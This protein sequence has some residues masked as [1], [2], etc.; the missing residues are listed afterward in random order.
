LT[1]KGGG[2]AAN[3]GDARFELG[4][5]VAA[6]FF[7][8]LVVA[9]VPLFST[10]LPPLVDY[11]NHLARLHLLAEGGNAFYAV[12]WA[13][14]PDLAADL[15]VPPLIRLGVPLPFAGKAFVVLSFA[16]ISGGTVWLNRTATG[17]WRWWPLLAFLLLYNRSFLWGFI[18]YLFGLGL[19]LCGLALW[20]TLERR[21]RTRLLLSLPMALG[22]FLSHLAAFGIYALS[23]AGVELVP[24]ASLVRQRRYREAAARTALA[25]PQFIAPALLF[26]FWQPA[27]TGGAVGF[28]AIWRKADLLFS[29]FDNYSRPFDIVC[30]VLFAGSLAVLAWQR[31]LALSPRLG[32]ALAILFAAYLILPTRIFTGYGADHR[33]PPALFLL[34]IASVKPSLPR[35]AGLLLAVAAGA[36]FA[37]RMAVVDAVWARA[38]GLYTSD[39][40]ALDQLPLGARLM[41]GAPANEVNAGG[42]PQLHVAALAAARREAF[43]P[44]VFAHPAQQPMALRPPF[45]AAAAAAPPGA[46]WGA[47]VTGDTASWHAV[48]AGLAVYDYLALASRAGFDAPPRP[49]LRPLP[50]PPNFRLF[51]L[52]HGQPCF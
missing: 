41:A 4:I 28:G 26:L 2:A 7:V 46:V 49:C 20:L 34:L 10:V 40:A 17:R 45:D 9:C 31:R 33:L 35:R 29:V 44:T 52:E 11:P 8:L 23:I 37:A 48:Q 18:N 51:A 19:A 1:A 3:C 21:P 16:L 13:P 6:A 36:M 42:V 50:S 25:A 27:G 39:I 12:R 38:D 30:F 14:L 5:T 15:L 24:V 43:V 32:V 22:C 47:F